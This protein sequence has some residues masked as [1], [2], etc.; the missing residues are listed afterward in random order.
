M[1][2][3]KKS[4]S[5][6]PKFA[7]ERQGVVT[8]EAYFTYP[9]ANKEFLN[10]FMDTKAN[11]FNSFVRY[12]FMDTKGI[13]IVPVYMK[14][15]RRK[16]SMM[17]HTRTDWLKVMR[18]AE[19]S[20]PEWLRTNRPEGGRKFKKSTQAA[21]WLNESVSPNKFKPK[22]YKELYNE[23]LEDTK[24][25]KKY[26]RIR[27]EGFPVMAF[28][29][30]ISYGKETMRDDRHKKVERI[31]QNNFLRPMQSDD[32]LELLKPEN[33]DMIWGD[34]NMKLYNSENQ[35][36]IK[37]YNEIMEDALD[38][39]WK[40]IKDVDLKEEEYKDIS[41]DDYRESIRFE[42]TGGEPSFPNIDRIR[43]WFTKVGILKD[44]EPHFKYTAESY[45]ALKTNTQKANFINSATFLIGFSIYQSNGGRHEMR[46][47]IGDARGRRN[48][49]LTRGNARSKPSRKDWR[50]DPNKMAAA[51]LTRLLNSRARG[52]D[53][54]SK[55][56]SDPSS[57]LRNRQKDKRK[58]RRG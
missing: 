57:D 35:V 29:T 2:S 9:V 34:D 55:V 13:S 14:W 32:M 7:G 10:Y 18:E 56:R 58:Q 28:E 37:I 15:D 36:N 53:N 17:L 12:K 27:D 24:D 52:T 26:S 19:L 41:D 49:S 31:V 51:E 47:D 1:V 20:F 25:Q 22:W 11:S 33:Q 4:D 43:K 8:T 44:A 38:M 54:R 16:K 46:E 21:A 6:F 40:S 50:S 23:Y 45:M 42:Y 5:K 3:K 30:E 48:S 39:F